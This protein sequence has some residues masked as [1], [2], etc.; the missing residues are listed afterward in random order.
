MVASVSSCDEVGAFVHTLG[1]QLPGTDGFLDRGFF[2]KLSW[3]A[4]TNR[5]SYLSQP[6]GGLSDSRENGL[7][8]FRSRSVARHVVVMQTQYEFRTLTELGW[9]KLES[10]NFQG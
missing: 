9:I 10:C 3:L 4:K 6:G 2:D 8:A 1:G 7:P 5:M